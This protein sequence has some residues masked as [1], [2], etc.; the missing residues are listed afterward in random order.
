MNKCDKIRDLFGA[1]LHNDV[2]SAERAA[3][4][5]H[6]TNCEECAVDLRSRQKVLEML[7]PAPQP[8]EIPQETQDDFAWNVY[9]RIAAHTMKQRSR[10]IFIRRFVLQPA[11]AAVAVAAV[12]V[13]G[14]I[15]FHPGDDTA[16]KLPTVAAV[17]KI[18]QR[19]LRV[20]LKVEEFLERHGA[21]LERGS[22]YTMTDRVSVAD[23]SSSDVSDRVQDALLPD[24]QRRLEYASFIDYSLR[25]PRRALAAYR[26]LVDDYPGTDVAAEARGRIMAISG[27]EYGFQ[28]RNP[29]EAEI[30]DM[31]I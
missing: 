29:D 10:Q 17:D 30:A 3:V 13:I 4:E 2:T 18:D 31:G 25:D 28:V 15:Q 5:G 14:V 24:S 27:M 26:Q 8:D 7:R 19:E 16:R 22:S 11:F 1:Y 9:R 12:L 20:R 23:P 21:I 6:I